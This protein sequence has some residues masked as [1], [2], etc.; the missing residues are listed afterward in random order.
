MC[1][2]FVATAILPPFEKEVVRGR[3]MVAL[4]AALATY[5]LSVASAV[6][7]SAGCPCDP[8]L[9]GKDECTKRCSPCHAMGLVPC[10]KKED[11]STVCAQ[12]C[13]DD[14]SASGSWSGVLDETNEDEPEP[15]P[16]LELELEEDEPELEPEPEEDEPEPEPAPET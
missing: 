3:T 11:G 1:V 10:G 5:I 15:E 8:E 6:E 16:E 13:G 14:A 12:S 4:A 2:F 9:V 7:V